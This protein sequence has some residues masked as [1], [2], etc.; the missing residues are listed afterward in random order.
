MSPIVKNKKVSD[1]T[2][3]EFQQIIKETIYEVIDPDYGLE[4]KPEF[5]KK[6]K[7]SLKS[8]KRIPV[9]TVAKKLGLNW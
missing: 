9:E 5:V 1:M 7:A 6:L 8:K 2:I 3:R 4:L